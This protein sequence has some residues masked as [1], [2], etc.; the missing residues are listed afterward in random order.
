MGSR[1]SSQSSQPVECGRSDMISTPVVVAAQTSDLAEDH[2]GIDDSIE[3]IDT[4]IHD[5]ENIDGPR[6]VVLDRTS[7]NSMMHARSDQR[8]DPA[9]HKPNPRTDYAVTTAAQLHLQREAVPPKA[10]KA[11]PENLKVIGKAQALRSLLAR[12]RARGELTPALVEACSKVDR[13]IQWT[14]QVVESTIEVVKEDWTPAL[15]LANVSGL[16]GDLPPIKGRDNGVDD[17]D[18]DSSMPSIHSIGD[19]S[20]GSSIHSDDDNS[21]VDL[22]QSTDVPIDQREIGDVESIDR[23][24]PPRDDGTSKQLVK[25]GKVLY[26]PA[27]RRKAPK[28]TPI[29]DC[30][31]PSIWSN[32]FDMQG[33]QSL[34]DAVCDAYQAWWD[35]KTST[36]N[37]IALRYSVKLGRGW[38]GDEV[39][40]SSTRQAGLQSWLKVLRGGHSIALAC[41]CRD[42]QRCHTSTVSRYLTSMTKC[43]ECTPMED[44]SQS[45]RRVHLIVYA[46]DP[47]IKTRLAAQI[48]RQSPG[49]SVREVDILN[50]DDHDLR[51]S[52]LL[53]ELIKGILEGK[54]ASVHVAI[55]CSS[56][57]IVRGEKLRSKREPRGMT[58]IPPQWRNYLN[59]HNAL[60]DAGLDIIDACRRRGI[61]W[62]LENPAQRADRS[63]DAY[64]ERFEDWGF[65]W[66]LDRVKDYEV[67]GA[68]R[69]LLPHCF[70][71][72]DEQKYIEILVCKDLVEEA[73]RLFKGIKCQHV[74]HKALACGVDIRGRSKAAK[75]AAYPVG[76][77]VLLAKLLCS[78]GLMTEAS[79]RQSKSSKTSTSSPGQL[80]VGSS[81]PHSIAGGDPQLQRSNSWAK[82]G[83]LRQLEPELVT[84]LIREPLP[85]TNVVRR[86]D[87]APPLTRPDQV[88]GPFT[89]SQLIP[90][91]VVEKVLR[92][93]NMSSNVLKRAQQGR[94]GW[95][96]AKDLRPEVEVFLEHEALN[97]CGFGFAWRRVDPN[98][99]LEPS[100]LWEALLP[101]S[102]PDNPPDP[103]G[104]NAVD[105]DKFVEL[106]DKYGFHDREICSFF[107][108]GFPG[109]DM[110]NTAVLVPM[111]VG[112]LKEAAAYEDR[113]QRDIDYDFITQPA[114]FPIVWPAI[115]DPCNIVVQNGAPRL[116]IDKT[117]WTSGHVDLPP[118]NLRIDL[119]A[120]S[121]ALGRLTLPKVWQLT[122]AAAIF[123][124]AF[125]PEIIEQLSVNNVMADEM[126]SMV[127]LFKW[128]LKAFFR[129]HKKQNVHIRESCRV[130]INGYS[131][132]KR[133]NFGECDA[134]LNT[135]RGSDGCCLF[136]RCELLHLDQEYPPRMPI[137]QAFLA[138]RRQR[139]QEAGDANDECARFE[140]DVLFFVLFYVD[141]GAGAVFD[142]LLYNKKGEPC[143]ELLDMPD[144]SKQ[145]VHI[146]RA[147]KYSQACI[148]ICEYV[149]HQCPVDKR[150]GPDLSLVYLGILAD[151]ETQRRILP[152][153][154]AQS[155]NELL[156]RC[157]QGRRVMP[158][159]LA[160]A[161][162]GD[163]NSLTHKLLHASDCKPLGRQHL[164]YCRQ[165]LKSARQISLDGDRSMLGVIITKAVLRELEWWDAQLVYHD[166]TGLPLASRYSFPGASSENVLVR[167]SDASREP[168]KAVCESGGGGWALIRGV[169]YY[170]AVTWTSFEV[171][172]YSINV[173]EAH[174][175]DMGGFAMM[176]KAAELGCPITHTLAFVD[177]TTAEHIAESGRASTAMLNALNT[178]RLEQLMRR[179]IHEA[180]ERVTSV[181]NDV[182]DLLSRG[183]IQEALRFPTDCGLECVRLD[184]SKYRELPVVDL[185]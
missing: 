115:C 87:P 169:F 5:V 106:A 61:R 105:A 56:Y 154:K 36:S 27:W 182:A 31:R 53:K 12:K 176:D 183:A 118:Y 158:N 112:A 14:Q 17:N 63:T 38:S 84:V 113:N 121:V 28:H 166:H 58:P 3:S 23:A 126:K 140:W 65:L 62:T 151:L 11:H 161:N 127:K 43:E 47:T 138:F 142:D 13:R 70:F 143:I 52:E 149:R 120:K 175:R 91:G 139:R 86:T 18:S 173:L 57:A 135:C 101:S 163:F 134:P 137:L 89:T 108:Q 71:G 141:D 109:A 19:S 37:E 185:M 41:A 150:E 124:A 157:K 136:A 144:G 165:A 181:D 15:D 164:F 177:N 125:D 79:G 179:G 170:F 76:L 159:G 162:Y 59:K 85:R 82:T 22:C 156:R 46:G 68:V 48:M 60:T 45:Q 42:D 74:K 111:H 180:N 8:D 119:Q 26:T 184:V 10:K 39:A 122:R 100:S 2:S 50:G 35:S 128:D 78:G 155:Y 40:E 51:N 97:P 132:D 66:D 117:M 33:K 167:Y 103:R 114:A 116:T 20:Y 130:T 64:W 81:S 72:S 49:D 131:I 146:S 83:S 92:F 75:T 73:Q 54:F 147:T 145:L 77:N 99:S 88:P 24:A 25:V 44:E 96:A 7:N 171:D 4:S 174:A 160:I 129:F 30:R 168:G 172:N 178:I 29:F 1:G 80:H 152:K 153:V 6:P 94:H 95:R 69:F 123:M 107:Q 55:P 133:V 93:G 102:W 21:S 16:L 32:P 9:Q 34:R 90:H 148:A 67:E 104:K 98:S 110:P